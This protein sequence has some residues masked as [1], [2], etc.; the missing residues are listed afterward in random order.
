[1]LSVLIFLPLAA[2]A[3]LLIPRISAPVARGV[4]VAVTAAELAADI[5]G[6]LGYHGGRA[7]GA[8]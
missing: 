4:F 8:A 1:M 2:A 5:A 6:P 3:V 7:G